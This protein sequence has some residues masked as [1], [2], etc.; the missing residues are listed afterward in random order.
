M[1]L[2]S[3][4]ALSIYDSP[5][6]A[7]CSNIMSVWYRYPK[8]GTWAGQTDSAL[9][10]S[11][12]A[13]TICCSISAKGR[14]QWGRS[15]L[16]SDGWWYSAMGDHFWSA[17]T[18]WLCWRQL[19]GWPDSTR[20]LIVSTNISFARLWAQYSWKWDCSALNLCHT[21]ICSSVGHQNM[22]LIILIY[23]PFRG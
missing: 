10:H 15:Q 20:L 18:W 21:S 12:S 7:N 11:R 5:W 17:G 4:P 2:R 16:P 6:S 14:W 13:C 1:I 23:S 3:F 22:P 9:S 8:E 19:H